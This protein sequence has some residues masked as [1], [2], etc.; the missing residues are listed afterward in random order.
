LLCPGVASLFARNLKIGP[1]FGIRTSVPF[2]KH[3]SHLRDMIK[4]GS[5]WESSR[6]SKHEIVV[7]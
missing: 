6:R 2:P 4:L 1:Y 3:V 7:S 5:G